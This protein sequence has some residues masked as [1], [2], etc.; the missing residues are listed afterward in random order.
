MQ[1]QVFRKLFGFPII[2]PPPTKE[3]A[4]NIGTLFCLLHFECLVGVWGRLSNKY[5]QSLFVHLVL[6]NDASRV[7]EYFAHAPFLMIFTNFQILPHPSLYS[8]RVNHEQLVCDQYVIS[9]LLVCDQYD[10]VALT[11]FGY[12]V[13]G[14]GAYIALIVRMKV[15]P[16]CLAPV[17]QTTWQWF[18]GV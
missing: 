16:H 9:M 4:R 6:E 10:I 3:G 18:N 11:L 15:M 7:V 8:L 14:Q 17:M 12:W 5:R 2:T 13:I 1:K